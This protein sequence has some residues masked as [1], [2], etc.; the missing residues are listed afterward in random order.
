[1]RPY[2]GLFIGGVVILILVMFFLVGTGIAYVYSEI[3]IFLPLVLNDYPASAGPIITPTP[4]PTTSTSTFTPTPTTSTSTFTPTPTTT[5]TTTPTTGFVRDRII[6]YAE[7]TCGTSCYS[8][9]FS[10]LDGIA[11]T[12]G[13]DFDDYTNPNTFIDQLDE[14][15]VIAAIYGAGEVDDNHLYALDNFVESGG[16]VFMDYGPRWGLQNSLF[17][18]LFGISISVETILSSEDILIYPSSSLPSWMDGLSVGVQGSTFEHFLGH[19]L[20]VPGIDG[21]RRYIVSQETGLSRLVYYS[22][23]DEKITFWP[24]TDYLCCGWGLELYYNFFYDD[25]NIDYFDNETAALN[26]LH[27]LLGH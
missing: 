23:P 12:H 13:I 5:R 10:K 25:E 27:F 26:M 7:H 1:M 2:R 22:S 16:R 4:T 15:D 11:F 14:P 20:Y 3:P 24:H 6:V 21:E 8:K 19:Y 17:Q 18:Q 9:S